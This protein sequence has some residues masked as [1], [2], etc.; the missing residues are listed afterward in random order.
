MFAG[1]FAC[2]ERTDRRFGPGVNKFTFCEVI[3]TTA[4]TCNRPLKLGVSH[5]LRSL[6]HAFL[7]F[8]V[9]PFCP[10]FRIIYASL[11]RVYPSPYGFPFQKRPFCR[12]AYGFTAKK[13]GEGGACAAAAHPGHPIQGQIKPNQTRSNQKFR[14]PSQHSIVPLFQRSSAF[15]PKNTRLLQ[16]SVFTPTALP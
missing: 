11:T 2:L 5:C 12:E 9:Q 13:G 16:V 1:L 14:C 6:A 8:K 7:R 3:D 15:C 10:V 4:I